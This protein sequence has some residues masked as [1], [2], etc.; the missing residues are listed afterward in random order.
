[1]Q[2]LKSLNVISRAI[3]FLCL[4]LVIVE[5]SHASSV[6]NAQ[7]LIPGLEHIQ[8][9]DPGA[10]AVWFNERSIALNDPVAESDTL[11][12]AGFAAVLSCIAFEKASD[13]RAYTAWAKSIEI[14]LRARTSWEQV[15]GSL[16]TQLVETEKGLRVSDPER[17]ANGLSANLAALLA[18][19][20]ETE[21]TKYGGPQ[22]GLS[23]VP[24]SENEVS[25]VV[26][27]YFARPLTAQ[28]DDTAAEID[29]IQ[30]LGKTADPFAGNDQK[31]AEIEEKISGDSGRSVIP[32][33]SSS[34][35][36]SADTKNNPDSPNEDVETPVTA[37]PDV[38]PGSDGDAEAPV[39]PVPQ[40]NTGA[41]REEDSESADTEIPEVVAVAVDD[42]TTVM[43]VMVRSAGLPADVLEEMQGSVKTPEVEDADEKDEVSKPAP[44]IPAR[45][46]SYGPEHRAM[47]E[48][49]WKY[50]EKN[51]LSATGFVNAIKGYSR[52][53]FWDVG[54]G[55]AGI[56]SAEQLGLISRKEFSKWM[57]LYLRSLGDLPLYNNELPNREY[58]LETGRM[59]GRGNRLDQTG[60][61]WSAL[62]IG[63]TLIWLRIAHDWYPDL[64]EDITGIVETWDFQR[65]LQDQQMNGAWVGSRG[66]RTYQEGRLGYEQYSA[67]G[68][69]AWGYDVARAVNYTR[70]ATASIEGVGVPYDTGPTP[71]LTA[72]PFVL[73][74]IELGGID[75]IFTQL[76]DLIYTAHKSY[77][78][79]TGDVLIANED[80][81]D[82][83]PWFAYRNVVYEDKPWHCVSYRGVAI[84]DCP[85][86]S[87]KGAFGLASIFEDDYSAAVLKQASALGSKNE[88]FYAGAYGDGKPNKSLNINTNSIVLEALLFLKRGRK[89]FLNLS[90]ES[91]LN[92][93][94][95]ISDD[96]QS[97]SFA[98][99]PD[100]E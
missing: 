75:A 55:I 90:G 36:E 24:G 25:T 11:I 9:N 47:A 80:S 10:G 56:V 39:V 74:T 40:R 41:D 65:L 13:A 30:T 63:R 22:T 20:A 32:N 61:G 31:E 34:D 49:A 45:R 97:E 53:T 94:E 82:K 95:L 81:L 52:A 43:G 73:A 99:L 91:G 16:K 4:A 51:R 12:E 85:V 79:R 84:S 33:R 29:E 5:T 17:G 15:R 88:G 14:F 83:K 67:M 19:E 48:V 62:D 76:V 35:L 44:E 23:S 64:R 7:E 98:P 27:S 69:R 93:D 42:E 89:P 58:V 1:M 92:A 38:D 28:D 50:F 37:K 72:D 66:E 3:L 59:V 26:K 21:F 54:S 100:S 96:S 57:D 68:Y 46:L 87:T 2:T 71:F 78:D 86:I 70:T 77:W 60:T 8:N 6:R 18:L